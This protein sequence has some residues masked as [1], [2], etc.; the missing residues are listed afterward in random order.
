MSDFMKVSKLKKQYLFFKIR[1][2]SV[3]MKKKKAD[4]E[5]LHRQKCDNN[6]TV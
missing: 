3:K 6:V 5:N 2:K 4:A 1:Q